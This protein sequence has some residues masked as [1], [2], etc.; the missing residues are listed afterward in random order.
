MALK[1]L[2]CPKAEGAMFEPK[3]KAP[4]GWLTVT[5]EMSHAARIETYLPQ[6]LTKWKSGL[7]ESTMGLIGSVDGLLG[8]IAS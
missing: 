6:I 3:T 5:K 8:L 2:Q 7:A 4:H 1:K